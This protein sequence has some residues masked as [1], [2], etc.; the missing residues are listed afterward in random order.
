MSTQT[1]EDQYVKV[2]DIKTRFWALGDE[3]TTVIMIHGI[4]GF[5]ENWSLNI[6]ALAQHHRVYAID[7][8]GFGHSD[9]PPVPF[10]F[11]YAPMELSLSMISWRYNASIGPA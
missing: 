8:A 3:G 9:Q 10:T 6:D 1:P 4:S 7:L 2:G 11:S 5:V